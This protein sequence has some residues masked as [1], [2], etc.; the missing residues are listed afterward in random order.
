MLKIFRRR[1]PAVSHRL[2]PPEEDAQLSKIGYL[3]AMELFRE[4]TP[5]QMKEIERATT[6]YSC[7]AG[8]VC[9]TPG[10]T[11]E[12][13]FILKKGAVHIYRMSPEGRKLVIAELKP[14]AFFGEMSILG[15]GMYDSFAEASEDSLVCTMSRADVER[16]ILS[17]PQVVLRI[18]QAVGKRLV[19]V[20]EMLEDVAFKGLVPRIAQLLLKEADGNGTLGLSHQ[21]IADRLG[22]YR[23]STTVA[24]NQM[25]LAGIIEIGRKRVAILDRNRLE[26]AAVD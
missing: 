17:R 22:V 10:Q 18:L 9:Y 12:V 5:E 24:L 19:E 20:E 26:H 13:L 4:L 16:L 2:A 14:Y 25:K 6:M 23:E 21:E 8:G 7:S 1:A 3:S 11:G 15:Q